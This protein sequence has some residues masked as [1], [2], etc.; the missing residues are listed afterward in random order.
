MISSV[1]FCVRG[2]SLIYCIFA[3]NDAIEEFD[4][5]TF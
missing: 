2:H 3:C 5:L 4:D 1:N